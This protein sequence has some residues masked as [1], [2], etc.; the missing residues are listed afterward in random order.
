MRIWYHVKK[1]S[2]IS[3]NITPYWLGQGYIRA[4]EVRIRS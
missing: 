3:P 4:V 2:Q 1:L